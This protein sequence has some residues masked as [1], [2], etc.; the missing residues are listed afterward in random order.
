MGT[1]VALGIM[2]YA[3]EIG[4]D[5]IA[6]NV[7]YLGVNQPQGLYGEEY[8][9]L[10]QDKKD[11]YLADV[12]SFV[13]FGKDRKGK[14][15]NGIAQIFDEKYKKLLHER[16]IYEHLK[17]ILSDWDAYKGTA[18]GPVAVDGPGDRLSR[19]PGAS[20]GSATTALL[21]VGA[22]LRAV[23]PRRLFA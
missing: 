14:L 16:G 11:Y 4:W 12:S 1:G 2:Y 9:N 10:M 17:V 15:V 18:P 3:K 8:E 6:L 22:P 19:A 13:I 7:I 5:K 21:A 23:G 20:P